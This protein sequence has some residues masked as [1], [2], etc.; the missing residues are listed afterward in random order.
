MNLADN[1]RAGSFTW[2]LGKRKIH[3]DEPARQTHTEKTLLASICPCQYKFVQPATSMAILLVLH[4]TNVIMKDVSGRNLPQL[5]FR[6][7]INL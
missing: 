1:L 4:C 2:K 5:R 7:N 6:K 3:D